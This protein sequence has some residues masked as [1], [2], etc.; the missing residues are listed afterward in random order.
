M[1]DLLIVLW[2]YHKSRKWYKTIISKLICFFTN[3][4]YTHVSIYFEGYTYESTVMNNQN[5][6]LK[7]M[8]LASSD[9]RSFKYLKFRI[10]LN[11]KQHDNLRIVL[12]NSIVEAKPYNFLKLFILAIVYPTRKFWN[13]LGWVPFQA[14]CFGSVCSV[15]VD[16]IF[17][18][19]GIDLLPNK[20]E[21]YTAPGD[22]IKNKL[23]E[24]L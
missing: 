18:D 17:K 7:T 11:M 9:V 2:Q 8:G 3:S 15:Y 14:E 6:A 21:E 1:E 16:Q 22:F 24:E 13:W 5:G 12:N 20:N 23:L 4:K 10:P 19:M